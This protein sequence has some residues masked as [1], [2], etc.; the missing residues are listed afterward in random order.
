MA[1]SADDAAAVPPGAAVDRSAS[2]VGGYTPQPG[3]FDEMVGPDGAVRP[4]WVR[5]VA[6][7]DGLGRA[8]VMRRWEQAQLLIRENG[9]SYNVYGDDRGTDRPW[10]LS[11][12]PLVIG[13]DEWSAI[14]AALDQRARLCEALLADLYGPQRAIAEGWLPPELVFGHPS[15][16][17]PCVGMQPAGG[18]WLP[19]YAADLARG[20]DGRFVVLSDRTQVPS[21]AGYAL[22]NRIVI[23]RALPE[24]FNDCHV[25]RLA[26][27][28]QTMRQSL[29]AL[30]P[31][32]PD[33]PRIVLLTPGPYNATYFEQ[34]YL[35]QYLGYTLVNGGDLTV[36]SNRV[37]LKT[38]GGLQPVDVILRRVNDDF[39]D[40]LELRPDSLLGVPGLVQAA[41]QGHV[42]VASALGSGLLQTPALGA[43]LDKLAQHYLGEPLA[44]P[45]VRTWWCGAA[46]ALAEVLARLPELVVKPTFGSARAEPVFVAK[47]SSGERAALEARIRARPQD[48]VAQEQIVCSTTP[49]LVGEGVEPRAALL[50]C[51]AVA[52]GSPSGGGGP[53]DRPGRPV[54]GRFMVMPGGLTRVAAITGEPNVSMQVGA[55]A[56]DTWVVS[57]APVEPFTLLPPPSQ[58]VALSRGG[59]DLPSRAADNLFWLG[60]Y[61]ERAE[62]VA[63]LCRVV[64]AR[65]AEV[66]GQSDGEAML[67][68]APLYGALAAQTELRFP[69]GDRPLATRGA[70]WEDAILAAIVDLDRPAALVPVVRSAL[71][72]ARTVRDRISS[73]TWRVLMALDHEIRSAE[74]TLSRNWFGSLPTTLN[75]VVTT[76]AAFSGLAMESMSRGHAWRFLDMGRRLERASGLLL[77]LRCTLV[78]PQEREAPL[79]E[80]VLEVA[81]SAMTYRRRYLTA[82]QAAPVVDLLL[83]DE[84]NPRS[85]VY[86][87]SALDESVAAL[88]P[89]PGQVGVRSP[90]E[91]L[92]LDLLSQL[93]LAEVDEL[94]RVGPAGDRPQLEKLF[95]EASRLMPALSDALTDSYLSHA[96]LSRHLGR[97]GREGRE[98]PA[99]G[100]AGGATGGEGGP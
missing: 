48:F 30:A 76:L 3:S 71:R 68:I 5:F 90:P 64:S 14:A 11:P 70:R 13:A 26:R 87:V 22:E 84:S 29:A 61:A 99:G 65:S 35:A 2:V 74:A 20:P 56:K 8:E 49:V 19:L 86:Q 57:G 73:D 40:P 96:S 95:A 34:A 58:P 98:G 53:S 46:G 42:A 41:R 93:R 16:L 92:A 10:S 51:F 31:H 67:Y 63:R 66:A 43:Y 25:E 15:Y 24:L 9:V 4:P 28:F 18:R 82:L 89:T 97:E 47:L 94:C 54:D 62:M 37:F 39:C 75:H 44:L 33:N 85:V 83:T 88:P 60:R 59:G 7:L 100:G 80:A 69:P 78:R 81:D 91:K 23:S 50:R 1:A 36:R 17:R 79:L 21:G 27:F 32:H 77:L 6:G 52:V 12:L 55:R 45:S 72:S 38:L